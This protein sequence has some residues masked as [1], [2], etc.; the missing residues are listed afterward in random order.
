MLHFVVGHG[1]VEKVLYASGDDEESKQGRAVVGVLMAEEKANRRSGK[2]TQ[3]DETKADRIVWCLPHKLL[4]HTIEA[5]YLFDCFFVFCFWCW[6]CGNIVVE[7][8]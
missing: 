7:V 3:R 5:E 2:G 1:A 6:C 4:C 8:W